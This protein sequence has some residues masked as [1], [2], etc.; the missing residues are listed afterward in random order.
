MVT[1]TVM[2]LGAGG[3]GEGGASEALMILRVF[4]GAEAF[5]MEEGAFAMEE[6][7]FVMEEGAFV[8]AGEAF[9]RVLA[10]AM[11]GV[12]ERLP[13]FLALGFTAAMPMAGFGPGLDV[14]GSFFMI[15]FSAG[16]SGGVGVDFRMGLGAFFAS[17]LASTLR[18]GLG[19]DFLVDFG[20]GL[21]L[22]S[23]LMGVTERARGVGGVGE[24]QEGAL[25]IDT[26]CFWICG[27]RGKVEGRVVEVEGREVARWVG[28]GMEMGRVT[29][30]FVFTSFL[31]GI[32]N[33][34]LFELIILSLISFSWAASILLVQSTLL[35]LLLSR[36][37]L[38]TPSCSS[39]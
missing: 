10:P 1:D 34:G 2:V 39:S 13:F 15:D 23:T 6:G 12:V 14:L 38:G 27:G 37:W 32:L 35:L 16:L 4:G 24:G 30:P 22:V 31:I 29:P 33:L 19:V 36:T 17:G 7:A 9:A 3:L 11:V 5:A 8:M 25:V 21:G 18:M 26:V 28:E 20:K